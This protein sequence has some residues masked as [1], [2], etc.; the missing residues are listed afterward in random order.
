[1]PVI[2]VSG[3]NYM[4]H[5]FVLSHHTNIIF[6]TQEVLIVIPYFDCLNAG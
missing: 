5:Y 3:L 6:C 1:M 4:N 2:A